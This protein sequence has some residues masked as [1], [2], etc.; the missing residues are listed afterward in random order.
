MMLIHNTSLL[1]KTLLKPSMVNSQEIRFVQIIQKKK[2]GSNHRIPSGIK[3]FAGYVVTED[4][5]ICHSDSYF[6]LNIELMVNINIHIFLS[7]FQ[8]AETP[9]TPNFGH[10]TQLNLS[11]LQS[12]IKWVLN[13]TEVKLSTLTPIWC[14]CVVYSQGKH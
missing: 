14:V 9:A 13:P 3:S 11:G 10:M 4:K 1:V 12:Y 7:K 5:S 2:K 8:L 6:L